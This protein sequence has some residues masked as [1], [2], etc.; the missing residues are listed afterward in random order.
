MTGCWDGRCVRLR[1]DS[2]RDE[3]QRGWGVGDERLADQST[4]FV[5]VKVAEQNKLINLHKDIHVHFK[6]IHLSSMLSVES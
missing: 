2:I 3:A 6:L 1:E 4:T 5:P